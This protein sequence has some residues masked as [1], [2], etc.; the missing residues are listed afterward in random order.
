M[1][2]QSH[3]PTTK[4]SWTSRKLRSPRWYICHRKGRTW[5]SRTKWHRPNIGKNEHDRDILWNSELL[6]RRSEYAILECLQFI[7][8]LRTHWRA[9]RGLLACCTT[10]SDSDG[11]YKCIHNCTV[12]ENFLDKLTQLDRTSLVVTS[13]GTRNQTGTP[14]QIQRL[15]YLNG[16]ISYDENCL[17]LFWQVL[18]GQCS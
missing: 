15:G 10:S 11:L 1:N 17:E 6:L 13:Y 18:E 4:S 2:L 8:N 7:G 16:Y 12:V 9:E 5:L 3:R 14:G